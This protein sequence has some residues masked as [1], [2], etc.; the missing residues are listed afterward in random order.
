[1]VNN[2]FPS[3]L[4]WLAEGTQVE[5]PVTEMISSVDL[6]EE[7]I[8]VAMGEKLQYKQVVRKGYPSYKP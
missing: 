8:R 3:F 4:F 1:M 2:A 7:Q 6:I 5:H